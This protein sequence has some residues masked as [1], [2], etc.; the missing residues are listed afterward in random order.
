MA[1]Q[2]RVTPGERPYGVES[3]PKKADVG[4]EG[5]LAVDLRIGTV[6]TVEEFPQAR[7][8][9]WRVTVDFGPLGTLQ[10]SAKITNYSAEQLVGRQIVGAVNLGTKRIAGFTSEFLILGGL[11]ADGTVHLLG[12]DAPLPPGSVI[13]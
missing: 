3:H 8:P 1:K 11:A 2:H 13:A 5:F 9:A 10:T 7:D 6:L 12:A 4:I